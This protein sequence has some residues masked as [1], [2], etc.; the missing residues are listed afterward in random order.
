MLNKAH[1]ELQFDS[2]APIETFAFKVF[3]SFVKSAQQQFWFSS[4]FFC[5]F[6]PHL[7]LILLV[8]CAYQKTIF[9]YFL[10]FL[11]T[12]EAQAKN[13]RISDPLCCAWLLFLGVLGFTFREFF[14]LA[15]RRNA[16]KIV[17]A[18]RNDSGHSVPAPNTVNQQM[19]FRV[20]LCV[21]HSASSRRVHR[22]TMQNEGRMEINSLGGVTTVVEGKSWNHDNN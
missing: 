21:N 13:Q 15:S 18:D 22:D 16:K 2:C 20:K 1:G 4:F 7:L 10:F 12:K 3:F 5:V 9:F 8:C 19:F 6:L 17:S 14:F 11:T